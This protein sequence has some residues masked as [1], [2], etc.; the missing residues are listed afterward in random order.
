MRTPTPLIAGVGIAIALC[1]ACSSS[2][3]SKSADTSTTRVSTARG[4]PTSFSE[5]ESRIV[6]KVPADFVEQPPEAF[7]TG[8][9]DLAKAIK[10]DGGPNAGKVLRAEKF[11][12]GYQR[13]WIGPE[14]AQII[15]FIYQFESS[16]GARQDFARTTREVTAKRPSG[17]YRFV[18]PGLPADRTVGIAGASKDAAVAG[19]FFTKGV[20]N[21]QIN[22]NGER[23]SGLQARATAI[24][25]DQFRRL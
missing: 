14:H 1:G 2:S 19:V 25:K 20:F 5:L 11:V 24:A 8:P 10:D 4:A 6:T 9:S 15:V 3:P 13:I 21:V 12:R 23:L 17:A 18:I 16:A 22:C 7:D